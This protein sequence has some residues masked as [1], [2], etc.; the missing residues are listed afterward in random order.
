[1]RREPAARSVARALCPQALPPSV[2]A[3]CSSR[4]GL[5]GSPPRPGLVGPTWAGQAAP[6]VLS[7]SSG[8]CLVRWVCQFAG[9]DTE[10]QADMGDSDPHPPRVWVARALSA[11]VTAR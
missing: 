11:Q 5:L 7:F 4:A 2:S 6:G 3:V 9:E 8:A 10:T 1:M